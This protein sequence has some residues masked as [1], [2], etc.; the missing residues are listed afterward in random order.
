MKSLKTYAISM[1]ILAFG[2]TAGAEPIAWVI[3]S[4]GETL[5]QINLTTGE[6]RNNL[7][8]L[9]SDVLS[10]PNQVVVR[11][12]VAYVIC[13]G[14]DEIQL[15]NLNT[16][17]TTG[18]INTGASSNPYWMQFLDSQYVYVTLWVSGMLAKVDVV[19]E[20][21][22]GQWPVGDSPQ[23]VLIHDERVYVAVTAF[24]QGTWEYGQGRVV[25]FDTQTDQPLDT[26]N[27]GTNPQYLAR[28]SQGFLHVVCTGDYW[29]SFGMI[30]VIDP[31]VDAVVDSFSLGGSPGNLTIGPDDI[32]YIAAGGWG[33]DG[34]VYS[35]DALARSPLH[36][37]TNPLV[38][39]SGCA[40]AVAYQD[41][42]CLIG[43]FSDVVRRIDSSGS[44]IQ[45]FSLGDGPNH[46]AVR[47]MPGDINGDFQGPDVSD[48][49]Y[50]VTYMF[51]GGER[52][53]WPSRRANVNGDFSGP[54]VS[55]LVYL[56]TYM[57]SG[58]PPPKSAPVWPIY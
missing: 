11:D 43:G 48:L 14:T 53:L 30:Y 44:S 41:S 26:I 34:Y 38:V 8:A 39:D 5:S 46:A 40:M 35:F 42:T 33:S 57:F 58:G 6:A 18:Y 25:V 3:N 17:S 55:D 28:D 32:G 29:S 15:I 52:P 45:S 49:V 37:E 31:D 9:G 1:L 24:N 36:D 47:Y 56:V 19:N 4:S 51:S 20:T 22:A 27:V 21:V 16:E 2:V 23:G 7:V 50:L 10:Y 12:S 13:S 54:D